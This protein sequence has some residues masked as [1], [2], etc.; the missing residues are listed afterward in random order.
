[1][2]ISDEKVSTTLGTGSV[3]VGLEATSGSSFTDTVGSQTIVGYRAAAG[4]NGTSGDRYLT[5]IGHRAGENSSNGNSTYVGAYAGSSS[6]ATTNVDIQER[7][8]FFGAYSG[9]EYTGAW[10]V[11]LGTTAGMQAAGDKNVYI[12]VQTGTFVGSP[13]SLSSEN[14][15]IGYSSGVSTTAA[16][17]D[18]VSNNTIIGTESGYDSPMGDGNT[19]I[20]SYL[21]RSL[22]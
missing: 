6:L 13:S 17:M 20:G 7:N 19:I 3:I 12:G 11:M 18:G 5:A 4:M 15:I 14:V 16:D 10:S 1:M 8:S 9:Q 21:H 22:N 2:V